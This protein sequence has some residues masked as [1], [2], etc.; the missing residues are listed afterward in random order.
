[1]PK[2]DRPCVR[3]T[4]VTTLNEA[5]PHA[6]MPNDLQRKLFAGL[7]SFCALVCG[8]I[9]LVSFISRAQFVRNAVRTTGRIVEL[10][11][12]RS[13]N[14]SSFS[15]VFSFRD[16]GGDEHKIYSTVGSSAH[17]YKV[18]QTVSVLYR[19][20]RPFDARIDD[21]LSVWAFPVSMGI[22]TA[23]DLL[24]AL[25]IWFWPRILQIIRRGSTVVEVA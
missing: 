4:P 7:F 18:G 2:G 14:G 23:V 20:Q 17:G 24:F 22:V 10:Q 6:A 1:M 19:R 21:F 8:I 25:G 11:E 9:F 12:T 16:S 3:A 13:D 5:T 15:P